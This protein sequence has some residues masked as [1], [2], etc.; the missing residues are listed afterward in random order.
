LAVVLV[1]TVMRGHGRPQDGVALLAYDPPIL[2]L[3]KE[4]IAGSSPAMTAAV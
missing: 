2:L 4:W 3:A 1:Q